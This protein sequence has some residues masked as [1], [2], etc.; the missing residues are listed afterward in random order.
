M[1]KIFSDYHIMLTFF[2]KKRYNRVKK[3][4]IGLVDSF[5]GGRV[6]EKSG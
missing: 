1:Y 3:N 5:Y 4:D 2:N 6:N